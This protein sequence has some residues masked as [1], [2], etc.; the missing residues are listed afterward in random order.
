MAVISHWSHLV[1]DF[2]TSALDFY[3]AV[4]TAVEAREVPNAE[5]SRV[6]FKE[7]GIA[8]A[9]RE[10]LRIQRGKVVFDICA[11]PYGNAFF[12]SWWLSRLGPKHPWLWFLGVVFV[13]LTW[14]AMLGQAAARAVSASM[15]AA[16]IGGSSGG[17]GCLL[18]IVLFSLPVLV[19]A[20]GWSI[21]E[22][23]IPYEDEVLQ[24]PLLGWL[25]EKLF[26]PHSYYRYD[27][28]LMFQKSVSRAVNDVI[29][30]MSTGQGLRALSDEEK[31]PT[32]K[33][34]AR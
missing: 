13:A 22:G 12:F 10:Y 17:A 4:E 33:D 24:L 14:L 25:Y 9:K 29:D 6:Q 3:S 1:D 27:T 21:R 30:G 19:V 23:Y 28:A 8:S 20:L 31:T 5:F 26:N 7:G 16:L 18:W 15:N 34:L 32:L 2:D 11:A